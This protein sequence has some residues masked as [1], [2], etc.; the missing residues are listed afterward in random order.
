MQRHAGLSGSRTDKRIERGNTYDHREHGPVQITGI[1]Q[2][3]ATVGSVDR[4]ED[5]E[6]CIVRY[7]P[8]E[9]PHDEPITEFVE[10]ADDFLG[11]ID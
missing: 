6:V 2:G 1:W 9:A 8:Q 10:A 3:T 7:A 4:D 11:V 5:N